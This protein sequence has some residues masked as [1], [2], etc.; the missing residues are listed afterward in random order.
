[1]KT[2]VLDGL[3]TKNVDSNMSAK[4]TKKNAKRTKELR[5]AKKIVA[6]EPL[7]IESFVSFHNCGGGNWLIA[8]WL[9]PVNLPQP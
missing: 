8:E 1:M 7:A 4:P 3:V 9:E 5:Q 2:R 6:K